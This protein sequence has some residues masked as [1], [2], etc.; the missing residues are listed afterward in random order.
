MQRVFRSDGTFADQPVPSGTFSFDNSHGHFHLQ[1]L[2]VFRL[3][4]YTTACNTPA[5][6]ANCPVITSSPKEGFCL[7]DHYNVDG[8]PTGNYVERSCV[9]NGPGGAL[10]SQVSVGLSAGYEESYEF[11]IPH[12]SLSLTGIP[13]GQYWLE[14]EVNTPSSPLLAESY[15]GNN[16]T[17]VLVQ[18]S[19]WDV[20]VLLDG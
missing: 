2:V 19:D 16:V 10:E 11:T 8:A 13:N 7:F 20:T 17:R 3:R 1:N 6:S 14:A 18:I 9:A 15:T 4:N 5:T 12:Q